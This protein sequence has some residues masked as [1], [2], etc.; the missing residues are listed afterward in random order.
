MDQLVTVFNLAL[1]AKCIEIATKSVAI[2]ANKVQLYPVSKLW[3]P[4]YDLP[5]ATYFLIVQPERYAQTAAQLQRDVQMY[6]A[7]DF[8]DVRRLS[9]DR[10]VR[11]IQLYFDLYC[12]I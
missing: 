9:A 4:R 11:R 3:M 8:T 12:P 5:R 2:I 1:F 7:A 10:H 6:V